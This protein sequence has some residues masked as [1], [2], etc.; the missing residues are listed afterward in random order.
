MIIVQ[1]SWFDHGPTMM[2]ESIM[3][4][5]HNNSNILIVHCVASGRSRNCFR[6]ADIGGWPAGGRGKLGIMVLL[7]RS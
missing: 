4:L 3:M 7:S 2:L 5:S 1:S 6:K